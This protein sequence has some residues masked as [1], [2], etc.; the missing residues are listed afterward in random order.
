MTF[1]GKIFPELLQVLAPGSCLRDSLG[2][3]Y[4]PRKWGFKHATKKMGRRGKAFSD[5]LR[6]GRE[7]TRAFQ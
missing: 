7:D 1:A 3:Q 4:I 5:E 2:L 6:Q